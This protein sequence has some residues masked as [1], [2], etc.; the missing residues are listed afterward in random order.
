MRYLTEDPACRFGATIE[1]PNNFFRTCPLHDIIREQI[2]GHPVP[3]IEVIL[4]GYKN[5]TQTNIHY[6][7]KFMN[8]L[9]GVI[10]FNITIAITS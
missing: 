10:A 8:L 7:K 6:L 1:D 2:V 9:K 3:S 5:D 4:Y